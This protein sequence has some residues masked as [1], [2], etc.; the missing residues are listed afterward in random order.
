MCQLIW[1]SQ[2]TAYAVWKFRSLKKATSSASDAKFHHTWCHWYFRFER[3]SQMLFTDVTHKATRCAWYLGLTVH[4]LLRREAMVFHPKWRNSF[5]RMCVLTFMFNWPLA[6]SVVYRIRCSKEYVTIKPK[7]TILSR[8]GLH[9]CIC[10]T[11]SIICVSFGNLRPPCW[12]SYYH[13]TR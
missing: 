6:S 8:R 5:A 12:H 4:I 1:S 11:F 10:W 3:W 2:M 9:K 7:T 13:L